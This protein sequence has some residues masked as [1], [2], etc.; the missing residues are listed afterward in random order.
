MLINLAKNSS[1]CSSCSQADYLKIII[2]TVCQCLQDYRILEM[3]LGDTGGI[4]RWDRCEDR[5]NNSWRWIPWP[6]WGAHRVTLFF[7]GRRGNKKN[8]QFRH[9]RRLRRCSKWAGQRSQFGSCHILVKRDSVPRQSPARYAPPRCPPSSSSCGFTAREKE[10]LKP[11]SLSRTDGWTDSRTSARCI[12]EKY[13]RLPWRSQT[14][15]L[16]RFTREGVP[17]WD[18]RSDTRLSSIL[19]FSLVLNRLLSRNQQRWRRVEL[20][21]DRLVF[22]RSKY[23][24]DKGNVFKRYCFRG[25]LKAEEFPVGKFPDSYCR[26]RSFHYVHLR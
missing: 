15:S 1:S 20:L 2:E 8:E 11:R 13:N 17:F 26:K 3:K 22:L 23:N 24:E 14:A 12:K 19:L 21:R 6:G 18:A 16:A 4:S 7:D 10:R 9:G 25:W 5:A